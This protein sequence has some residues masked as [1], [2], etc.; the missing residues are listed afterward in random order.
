MQKT[1]SNVENKIT[2]R[3]IICKNILYGTKQE[4]ETIQEKLLFPVIAWYGI[5]QLFFQYLFIKLL[6]PVIAWYGIMGFTYRSN[7]LR[8]LFPVIAWYGIIDLEELISMQ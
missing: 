5:I 8:L 3:K 1:P 2:W 4:A 6:F 7:P